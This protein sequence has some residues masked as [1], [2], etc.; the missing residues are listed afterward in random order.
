[1]PSTI[2]SVLPLLL[3]A[4]EIHEQRR[5][6]SVQEKWFVP[7]PKAKKILYKQHGVMRALFR[8]LVFKL[9][10]VT[11]KFRT[12]SA[13]SM[14]NFQFVS[15][16]SFSNIINFAGSFSRQ[17]SFRLNV[18]WKFSYE[19]ELFPGLIYRMMQ[20]KIVLLIFVSGKVVLTGSNYETN[21]HQRTFEK[22][23]SS[24]R[25][26]SR[27]DTRSIQSDLSDS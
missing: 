5:L 7:A 10:F 17:E 16:H 23:L 4:F 9:N 27:R 11:L 8:N 25:Q 12:W 3:C 22:F 14:L 13:V 18:S 20:P 24:R 26:T 6:S 1:M 2:R 15:K 21:T 19:P